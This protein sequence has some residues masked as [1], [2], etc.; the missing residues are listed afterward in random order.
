MVYVVFF[1]RVL[2][3]TKLL[4]YSLHHGNC[5]NLKTKVVYQRFFGVNLRFC[6]ASHTV[7]H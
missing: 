3:V 2:C 4:T 7:F 5:S 6:F 1:N